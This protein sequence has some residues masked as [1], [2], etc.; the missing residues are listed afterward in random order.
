M[1]VTTIDAVIS[2]V[3]FVTEL[4]RLL[5]LKPLAGVPRRAIEFHGGPQRCDNYKY[6]AVNSD[7]S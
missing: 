5:S 3:V 7:F 4:D 2:N 6:R 1:T